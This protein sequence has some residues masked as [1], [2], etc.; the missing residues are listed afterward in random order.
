MQETQF[1]SSGWEDPLEKE[2]ATTAVLLPGEFH[3]QR[4]LA[5]YSPQGCK[6]LGMTVH[7]LYL[8]ALS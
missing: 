4:S 3:A 2:M 5:D 6:E 8:Q 7:F 1:Q